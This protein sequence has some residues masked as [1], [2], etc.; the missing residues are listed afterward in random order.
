LPIIF[1]NEGFE[2]R[3]GGFNAM[4]KLPAVFY[5]SPGIS[6]LIVAALLFANTS[7]AE[8]I[9]KSTNAQG[10]VIFSDEPPPNAVSVEQIEVQPAPT[11]AEHRESM[12]RIKRMESQANE[13]GAARRERSPQPAQVPQTTEEQPVGT[14]TYS[15]FDDEQRR[16]QAIIRKRHEGGVA[17]ARPAPRAGGGG[18]GR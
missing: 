13:M 11:D 16:Q 12:E 15:E 5:T 2:K 4:K 8:P 14:H 3:S 18:R 7:V 9:Y 6:V 17:P 1:F 10:Q